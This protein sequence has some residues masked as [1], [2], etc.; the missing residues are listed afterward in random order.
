MQI[1]NY[2]PLTLGLLLL[3]L[4]LLIKVHQHNRLV[5]L[6]HTYQRLVEEHA[7]LSQECLQLRK[8]HERVAGYD[9]VLQSASVA[10]LG[11]LKLHR[12]VPLTT[13]LTNAR[14]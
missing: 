7:S 10:P 12:I 8:Q 14:D 2:S 4:A 9:V 1:Y 6:T 5:Y 13:A 3:V 11:P